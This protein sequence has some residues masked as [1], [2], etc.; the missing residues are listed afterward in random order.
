MFAI[1]ACLYI[2]F[3]LGIIITE[4]CSF[5]IQWE[6]KCM[7]CCYFHWFR[8][9]KLSVVVMCFLL[10]TLVPWYFWGES[11]RVAY[12]VPGLLRYTVVLNST[13]LVNSAAHMWGMR[14]FDRNINPRENRFVAFSAVGKGV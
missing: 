8:Y 5:I 7:H 2:I 14:P 10:P 11:L 12:F 3:L 9:Y 6:K 1:Y 4:I 13:W